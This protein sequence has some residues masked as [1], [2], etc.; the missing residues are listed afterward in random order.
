MILLAMFPPLYR[1]VMHPLLDEW[2]KSS[3]PDVAAADHASDAATTPDMPATGTEAASAG[4]AAT[5]F[6]DTVDVAYEA[7]RKRQVSPSSR[8]A[9][10][11]LQRKRARPLLTSL[12]A[13]LYSF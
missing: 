5:G 12:Q 6:T 9:E 11:E 8:C 13:S 7:L 1:H 4:S 10:R 2:R 3:Y